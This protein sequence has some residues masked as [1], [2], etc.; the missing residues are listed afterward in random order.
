MKTESPKFKVGDRVIHRSPFGVYRGTV[1]ATH[2]RNNHTH[3][4][5]QDDAN[6]WTSFLYDF[7]L[8]FEDAQ[9]GVTPEDNGK[10]TYPRNVTDF[11]QKWQPSEEPRRKAFWKEFRKAA[12]AY[13]EFKNQ[14]QTS[15]K[16]ESEERLRFTVSIASSI[17]RKAHEGQFRRDGITP[18]IIHPE[19]VAKSLGGEHPYVIAAAWLHDVLEDTQT[20]V[21]HLKNAGIPWQVIDAVELLTRADGQPYEDYLHRIAQDEIARKVK[22]A[23]IRHNLS[24]APTEKQI[25]KYQK[26][27]LTLA[28]SNHPT[29]TTNNASPEEP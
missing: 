13:S 19:A 27:L 18:Y 3:F 7:Q 2:A 16:P 5:F 15:S 20:S 26:A 29:Q 10:P 24:D 25:S 14:N 11:I 12:N 22:I 4:E 9:V 1:I 21:V 17:A 23:D 8:E 28:N 6:G